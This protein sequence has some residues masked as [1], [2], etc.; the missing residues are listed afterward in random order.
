MPKVL[1]I[2]LASAVFFGCSGKTSTTT[3][4]GTGGSSSVSS[5]PPL[6]GSNGVPQVAMPPEVPPLDADCYGCYPRRI[7]SSTPGGQANAECAGGGDEPRDLPCGRCDRPGFTCF[8]SSR[9][10]CDC[11]QGSFLDMYWDVWNC[12]CQGGSWECGV[13]VPSGASCTVCANDG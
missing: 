6:L 1:L 3:T 10:V 2:L 5:C 12:T 7:L 13:V 11:G 9:A 4:N 8:K